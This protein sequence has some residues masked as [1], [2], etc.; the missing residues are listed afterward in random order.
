VKPSI[1]VSSP[2]L[3][4]SLTSILEGLDEASLLQEVVTTVAID[5][6]IFWGKFINGI[7]AVF[8]S[9]WRK[10]IDRRIV[11]NFLRGKVRTLYWREVFRLLAGRIGND[12]FAHRVWLWADLAFDRQVARKYSGRYQCIYG[13]EHSS[14]ETFKIQKNLGGLCILRQVMAHG[15]TVINLMR[16]EIDKFQQYT[17]LHSRVFKEDME[18]ALARKEAEYQ[19]ADL[20]VANSNFVKESFVQAGVDP[21]KVVAIPTGCPPCSDILANSGRG[22]TP[23]VFLFVGTLPLRKGLPYLIKAWRLLNPGR[24]A[25]LWLVGPRE[26]PEILSHDQSNGIHYFGSVSKSSLS[27]IYQQAD[28]LVLPTL[29]EGLAHVV[30]EALS[31]GMPIITTK[32]SGG[33]DFVQNDRNGFVIPSADPEALCGAMAWCLENRVQL[34][35]MGK[36]SAEQAQTWTV[37]NSNRAHLAAI[38]KFFQQNNL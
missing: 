3:R 6:E 17:N 15:R 22:N 27:R 18:R 35:G 24:I 12:V 4:P 38:Q 20:I 11:P 37:E 2:D 36:A 32:E 30:L 26:L 10:G 19:L 33:G 1:L 25:E 14:L 23:L 9:S 7:S 29:L 28:V 13:M 21:G 5:P 34:K 8:P 31:H 16:G